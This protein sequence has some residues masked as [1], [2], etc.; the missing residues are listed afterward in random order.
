MLD[1]DE[2]K[3]YVEDK[4]TELLEKWYRFIWIAPNPFGFKTCRWNNLYHI[5]TTRNHTNKIIVVFRRIISEPDYEMKIYNIYKDLKK[6][7]KF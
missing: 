4:N 1:E 6:E 7:I 2:T 5:L 3:K